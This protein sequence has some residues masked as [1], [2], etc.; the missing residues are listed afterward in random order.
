MSSRRRL[1]G[2]RWTT[3]THTRTTSA[4]TPA[5]AKAEKTL[6]RA[7]AQL[8]AK[9][10]ALGTA[11][12]LNATVLNACIAKQDTASILA[13]KAVGEK[14]GIGAT[15]TLFVNGDKVDGAVP[16]EFVFGIIDDALRAEGVQPPP[17]YV[18]PA[19]TTKAAKMGG[20]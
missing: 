8:D 3:S 18:A 17:P 1:I 20:Q 13:S 14:L 19:E 15:P 2:R 7:T 16:L 6:P 10:K 11:D 4:R 9:V 12:K 5:N